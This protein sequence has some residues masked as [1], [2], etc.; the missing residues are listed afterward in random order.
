MS[1][2]KKDDGIVILGHPRSGTTLLR[3]LLNGHENLHCPGETHVLNAC[4][5]FIQAEHTADGLDMGVLAGMSF[6]GMSDGQVL[7]KLRHFAFELLSFST[8]NTTKRWVEKTAAD[9]F[10]IDEIDTL[11][12]EHAKFIGIVRHGLDV[13]ISCKEFSDASGMYINMFKSYIRQYEQPIEAMLHSWMDV[14]YKLM[15]FAERHPANCLLIRYEDLLEQPKEVL[16]YVCEFINEP[17]TDNMLTEGLAN[18]IDLGLS[19][20]KCMEKEKIDKSNV[21]KWDKLPG[22]QLSRLAEIANPLLEKLGYTEITNVEEV[23]LTLARRQY[24]ISL[25]IKR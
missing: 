16:E 25:A 17:Y 20:P 3:R 10:Y 4:A 15:N 24:E 12:G 5:R 6:V 18:T 14:T 9:S 1:E 11:F 13:A 2:L 22:Y 23:S 19:D 7:D 21:N 8:Q